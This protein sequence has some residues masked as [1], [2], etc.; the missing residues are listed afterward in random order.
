MVSWLEAWYRM[1][2]YWMT[3]NSEGFVSYND[4]YRNFH[5]IS[6]LP[7]VAT[8]MSLQRIIA[9]QAD[10]ARGCFFP[11]VGQSRTE[12]DRAGQSK[13]EQ[14]RARQSRAGQWRAGQDRASNSSNRPNIWTHV[15]GQGVTHQYC[16]ILSRIILSCCLFSFFFFCFEATQ[17]FLNSANTSLDF[18]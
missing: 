12:Q 16:L 17:M 13:A 11:E 5:F 7:A 1:N 15:N 2:F 6:C 3:T 4:L 14:D 8:I 10:Q 9:F 18:W